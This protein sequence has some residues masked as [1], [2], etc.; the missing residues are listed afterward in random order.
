MESTPDNHTAIQ[1]R[2]D[3]AAESSNAIDERQQEPRFG[4]LTYGTTAV[5]VTVAIWLERHANIVYQPF[6]CQLHML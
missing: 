3:V 2:S 1:E 6:H 5:Q 4:F